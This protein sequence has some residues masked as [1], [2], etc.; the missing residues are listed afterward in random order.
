MLDNVASVA[1]FAISVALDL[2]FDKG[3][4]NVHDEKALFAR[5]FHQFVYHLCFC[6]DIYSP[7]RQITSSDRSAAD[8]E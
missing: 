4:D 8:Q 7:I 3:E 1:S 2:V 5:S 6:Q